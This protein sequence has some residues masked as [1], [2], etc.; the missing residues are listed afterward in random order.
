MRVGSYWVVQYPSSN[1]R[2]KFQ[3]KSNALPSYNNKIRWLFVSI[4]QE[5]FVLRTLILLMHCSL[6]SLE[7]KKPHIYLV[8]ADIYWTQQ[9]LQSEFPPQAAEAK[10]ANCR[11]KKAYVTEWQTLPPPFI[12]DFEQLVGASISPTGYCIKAT[13]QCTKQVSDTISSTH[14]FICFQRLKQACIF[15]RFNLFYS[16]S[17]HPQRGHF[18]CFQKKNYKFLRRILFLRYCHTNR[19]CNRIVYHLVI[20]LPFQLNTSRYYLSVA[21][22]INT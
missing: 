17:S 12:P 21:K 2:F 7:L 16:A 9:E 14:H 5:I 6:K 15:S 4:L 19:C 11:A 10:C 8:G 1:K 3:R 20:L 13:T 18:K 22:K